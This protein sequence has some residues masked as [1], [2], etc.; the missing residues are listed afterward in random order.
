M[1]KFVLL[2]I[3]ALSCHLV[4]AQ[5][6]EVQEE[7]NKLFVG[8]NFGLAFGGYTLINIAPQLG[9]RFN[10]F[11]SAGL[12]LNLV[13]TSLKEQDYYGNDFSKTSQWVTG[14]S[15][16]TRFYPTQKFLIQIQP[17]ANYMFGNIKYYQ[18]TETEYKLNAEIVPSLLAGGG[19]VVPSASG[20][21][22]TTVM[23]DL[24]QKT[25]SPY[26]NRPIVSFG[27]NMNF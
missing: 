6:E 10:R 5:D 18:P 4:F 22:I 19:L 25:N 8:G 21:F 27:Y 3:F 14:L 11:V 15:M 13:Y 24:L 12:G 26:G 20:A 1:K 23:Y 2:V 9:Y 7:N 17:E 16:F